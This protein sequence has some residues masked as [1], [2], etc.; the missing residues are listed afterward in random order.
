MSTTR[1]NTGRRTIIGTLL[2][3]D[4]PGDIS[5]DAATNEEFSNC[6]RLHLQHWLYNRQFGWLLHP[7]IPVD[8]PKLKIADI[9]CG[10][11]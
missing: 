7:S 5:L 11:G 1:R 3:R 8:K 9:A 4:T 6:F 10:N 2:G